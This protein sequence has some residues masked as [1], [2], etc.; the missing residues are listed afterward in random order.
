MK[1]DMKHVFISVFFFMYLYSGIQMFVP[2]K[3]DKK[4][5]RLE[6]KK[7]ILFSNYPKFF[8]I[9]ASFLQIL[10]SLLIMYQ[11]LLSPI[12]KYKLPKIVLPLCFS[13]FISF[14]A[15]VT[16]VYYRTQVIPFLNNLSLIAAISYMMLTN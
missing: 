6:N 14:T 16:I 10:C 15:L 4:V 1:I 12:V 11:L 9:V 13:F 2:G 7:F 5:K 3:L 8:I